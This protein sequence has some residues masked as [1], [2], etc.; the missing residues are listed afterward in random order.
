MEMGKTGFHVWGTFEEDVP[1]QEV[2]EET[3]KE[4]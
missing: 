2:A 1:S 4:D 3:R